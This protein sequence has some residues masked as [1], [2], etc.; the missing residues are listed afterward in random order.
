MGND[1]VSRKCEAKTQLATCAQEINKSSLYPELNPLIETKRQFVFH[2]GFGDTDD[3]AA[4]GL[5][6]PFLNHRIPVE[7][8]HIL[9]NSY[10]G[11]E[12]YLEENQD[13][14]R[15]AYS[16][17]RGKV[18]RV[19]ESLFQKGLRYYHLA[20]NVTSRFLQNIYTT[21]N[22]LFKY[23]AYTD[24]NS[25]ETREQAQLLNIRMKLQG[26]TPENPARVTF[27]GHSGGGAVGIALAKA[28]Q[29]PKN[30]LSYVIDHLETVGTPLTQAKLEQIPPNVKTTVVKSKA[31]GLY[32]FIMSIR[33]L[34]YLAKSFG[35]KA[36][37]RDLSLE[38]DPGA[39]LNPN[40]S[41]VITTPG[42]SHCG[43]ALNSALM[44]LL[45]ERS[46]VHNDAQRKVRSPQTT[47]AVAKHP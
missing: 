13:P 9:D 27:V 28:S 42:D 37:E 34:A 35:V 10:E 17:T 47:E 20:V 30:K 23:H 41:T 44:S 4:L 31:D 38:P 2:S 12:A 16:S 19:N 11:P 6:V 5:A 21:Y 29:D 1:V 15:E 8:I 33:P 25:K 46:G 39:H 43:Y 22:N 36:S 45:V 7:N 3:D 24:A 26:F 32:E 40:T 18:P 14:K